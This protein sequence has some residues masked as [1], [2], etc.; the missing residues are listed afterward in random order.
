MTI[1]RND[2][3]STCEVE[4]ICDYLVAPNGTVEIFDNSVGCNSQQEV[5]EACETVGM[6]KYNI[7]QDL[8]YYPTPA[9]STITIEL[10]TQPSKN[11]TLTLTSTN[12][13]R[14]ITQLITESQTEIDISHLPVGIYIVKVWNDKEVMVRKVIKR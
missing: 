2:S 7:L 13:Q 3:L 5:E 1:I 4:S 6:N 11:T 10:P 14:L 8:N 12:G 9:Q